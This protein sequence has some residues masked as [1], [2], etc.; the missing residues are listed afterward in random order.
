MNNAKQDE[1]LWINTLKGACILLVVLY[2]TVL[3][4]FE[5]TMK[6]LSAGGF[7][8]EIWVQFNT[9]LSPL[10]M[11]AFFFVS[12]LLA[13]NGILNRPWK[14]VFTS[15]I[16]NLFYL[17][18]LWGFIQWWSIVGI[19][20]EIT[21]QRISQ[22]LNAAYAGSLFEFLKLTFLAMSTSWYLYGLGLY[23]LFAKLFHKQKITLLAVAV[24]LN[25]LA[26]EKIIPYWGPQSVAQYFLFFLLGAFWSQ[27][28]LRLSEWRRENMLP[29]AAL[30]A[31]SGLHI[32][33]GLDK[34][35]F[36]CILAVL[37][38]V[39]ACRWLNA[40]F[41]M[42]FL[43][44]IGRNTLQIYVIH[45]IFIE[46]FGMSAILY[47]L[48]HQLFEYAWFSLL[49]ACL[50][51]L[52]IVVICSVCSVAVWSLTNRGLGKSLFIFPTLIGMKGRKQPAG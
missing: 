22:N 8:A 38:S 3:P 35:L 27:T 24:V 17:Y 7:P 40:H 41:R 37:A 1:I 36:L 51:P 39:A 25:Y 29:W 5:G 2:H 10:R 4:G 13:T 52:A 9:V 47:A 26:V 6:Y 30:A 33:F 32:I 11:P 43:N 23:F 20:T 31:L 34:S 45:R 14:Q 18:I 16:T 48:H 15:R 21:G 46:F 19:S 12:G 42:T 28:M 49:W 50:Y 44:W